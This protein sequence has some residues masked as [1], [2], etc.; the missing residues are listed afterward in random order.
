MAKKSRAAKT[1]PGVHPVRVFSAAS[2]TEA[3]LIVGYLEEQGIQARM[4]DP[5][6][7]KAL[8]GAERVLDRKAGVGIVVSSADEIRA[9]ASLAEYRARPALGDGERVEE[10]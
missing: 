9:T 4:E 2:V 6:I 10:E 5:L 8:A 3:E 7:H 1:P